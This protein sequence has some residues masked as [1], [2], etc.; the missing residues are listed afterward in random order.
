MDSL[1]TEALDGLASAVSSLLPAVA[2]PDLPFGLAV[3]PHQITLTGLGGYVGNNRDP[4]GEIHGRRVVADVA[5]AVRTTDAH[6]LD[7]GERQVSASLIGTGRPL[8][9]GLGLLALTLARTADDVQSAENNVDVFTRRLV[10]SAVYEHLHPPASGEGVIGSVPLELDLAVTDHPAIRSIPLGSGFAGQFEVL[11]DPAATADAPSQWAFNAAAS[12]LEQRSAIRAAASAGAAPTAGTLLL[13]RSA[14]A[15]DLTVRVELASGG[16]GA[17]GVV[18][19]FTGPDDYGYAALSRG[20]DLRMI[21]RKSA[22]AFTGFAGG[23]ADP[24]PGYVPGRPARLALTVRGP[25][26]T[27]V[28]DDESVLAGV[29]PGI[30]ATGRVGFYVA[31]N[32]QASFTALDLTE[33]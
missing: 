10:F 16:T 7:A 29:D 18:F 32:T 6:R 26:V 4:I 1:N 5:V 31:G 24:G 14:P 22:G 30:P 25:A 20:P 19:R 11:D 23:L 13:L 21:G 2:L 8:F 17:I 33:F 9:S 3:L 12:Q 28:V 15:D 27:L